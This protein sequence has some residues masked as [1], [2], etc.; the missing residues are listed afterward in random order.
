[1]VAEAPE[2]VENAPPAVAS[3]PVE[4]AAPEVVGAAHP[5]MAEPPTAPVPAYEQPANGDNPH[6]LYAPVP[7]AT[8]TQA[9]PRTGRL[10]ALAARLVGLDDR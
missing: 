4:A 5:P 7:V 2:V 6:I 10:A 9:K 1:P 8:A 3:T